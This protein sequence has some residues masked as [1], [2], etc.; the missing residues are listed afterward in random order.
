MFADLV[1]A[2]VFILRRR[3]VLAAQHLLLAARHRPQ[4]IGVQVVLVVALSYAQLLMVSFQLVFVHGLEALV[5]NFRAPHKRVVLG[6]LEN[7]GVDLIG[8]RLPYLRNWIAC[9]WTEGLAAGKH[10][11]RGRALVFQ[12]RVRRWLYTFDFVDDL[13]VESIDR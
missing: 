5:E 7:D 2:Y 12:D 4:A 6:F 9:G 1:C 10:E 3:R 8:C 13:C 11:V